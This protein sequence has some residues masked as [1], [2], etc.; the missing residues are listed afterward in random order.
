MKKLVLYTEEEIRQIFGDFKYQ[1]DERKPGFIIIPIKWIKENLTVIHLPVLNKEFMVHKKIASNLSNV[2][3]EIRDRKLDKY[4]DA[5]DTIQNGG[6]FVARHQF[7]DRTKPLSR[8]S[9]AIAFDLNPSQNKPGTNGNIN[10]EIIEIFNK[11]NFY[12]GGNFKYKDP[13]HF[14]IAKEL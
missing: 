3:F 6:C 13:M 9:W 7:F 8:H 14:E 12:W 5:A 4:I 1:E 11:Y 10:P 2:F